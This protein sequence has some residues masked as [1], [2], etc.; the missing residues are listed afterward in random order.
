MLRE[1]TDEPILTF[2]K[3]MS[4]DFKW[5]SLMP[6]GCQDEDAPLECP[7]CHRMQGVSIDAPI[8]EIGPHRQTAEWGRQAIWTLAWVLI[9]MLG[10]AVY[11]AVFFDHYDHQT[12]TTEADHVGQ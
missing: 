11:A 5:T 9:F 8:Y 4:C 12:T 6:D 2:A 10:C 1:M 7:N 3:C